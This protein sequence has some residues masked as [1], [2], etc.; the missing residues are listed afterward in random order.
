MTPR[1]NRLDLQTPIESLLNEAINKIEELPPDER[2][3]HAQTL[4][5]NAKDSL[6]DYIDEQLRM[7]EF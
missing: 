5:S 4:I 7:T 6:S 2:L 1:R 3:T